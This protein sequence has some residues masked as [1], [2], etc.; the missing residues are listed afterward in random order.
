MA[1]HGK[2]PDG[3]VQVS[4]WLPADLR[5]AARA[6]AKRDNVSIVSIVRAALRAW[7]LA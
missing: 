4:M 6:K 2:R 3:F 7:V 1:W 5:E